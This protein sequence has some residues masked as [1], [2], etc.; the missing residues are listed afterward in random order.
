MASILSHPE[1]L[2]MENLREILLSRGIPSEDVVDKDKN[3]L[4][5]L[6]YRFIVPLPQRASHKKRGNQLD[7]RV[8]SVYSWT[9][10]PTD[11]NETERSTRGIKRYMAA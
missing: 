8:T 3:D 4:V 1:I 11:G 10:K 2:S 7:T 6:F 9:K 5:Q